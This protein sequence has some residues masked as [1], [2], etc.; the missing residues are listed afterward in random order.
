MP[1]SPMDSPSVITVE[2]IDGIIPSVNFS[3]EL[4]RWYLAICNT[5][6]AWFFVITDKIDDGKKNYR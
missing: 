6:G 3:R 4:F 1:Q 5:V 2:N